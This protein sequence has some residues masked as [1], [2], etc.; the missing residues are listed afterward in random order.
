MSAV[1]MLRRVLC[2]HFS[3]LIAHNVPAACQIQPSR[4][5]GMWKPKITPK[6]GINGKCW[7]RIVHYKDSYTVEPL[8]VTNLAGRD[9]V[10]GRVVAKGIGGGIKHKYH[11][12]NWKREGPK[13]LDEPPKEEKV[14]A[15]F[16]D[17]CRTSW[18][19][20]VASGNEMK[21][22]LA[23]ENMKPGMILKTSQAIPRNP[24]R[25]F[26]GDA[27]PLGALPLGTKVNCVEKYPGLGGF[28]IHA[29]GTEGTI[30]RKDGEDRIIV[31]VPSKRTFSLSQ[32]C[33][34]TVGRLSNVL[35]GSTPVGS[36]QRN[37]ELGNR[38]RSGLWQRKDGYCGRKIRPL[39][40]TRRFD[41]CEK[42]PDNILN[43]TLV[44]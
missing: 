8:E 35:H 11:W 1:A 41:L 7:R 30:L 18:V 21:Y 34:A 6:P 27:Y 22:I 2:T 38:P 39:P 32:H 5:A 15:V 29:A 23:T 4:N 44:V 12:I 17:G 25:A 31:Q 3:D 28:L 13:S 14:L 10:S 19:A 40:P 24:V 37:R 16:E 42:K 9:P 20:L 26:E 36:A 33:M 43:L